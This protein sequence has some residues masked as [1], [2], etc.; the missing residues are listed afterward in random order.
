M[1]DVYSQ[2]ERGLA[3]AQ[4]AFAMFGMGAVMTLRDFSAVLL[5]PRALAVGLAVQLGA[6]PLLA[7]GLGRALPVPAGIAAGLVLV[8]A[9][10][11]GTLS[12]LATFLGR[13]NVAL[14]IALTAVTTVGALATTPAL[15]RLLLGA[16][17][18]ADFEMPVA[19]VARDIAATL[20][21]PLAAGMALGAALPAR[22]A[23]VS[24]WSIRA[25]L[26]M[27]LALAVGAAGSG[28]LD[29]RSYGTLALLAVPA[30][31]LCGQLAA[32]GAGRLAGL[33]P[34]DRL[35]LGIEATLRNTNLALLVKASLAPAGAGPDPLGDGMLFV[36][37][38]YGGF[39]LLASIPPI[40]LHRRSHARAMRQNASSPASAG[41]AARPAEP[42]EPLRR[43]WGQRHAACSSQ[44]S[45]AVGA[46]RQGPE[47]LPGPAPAR[48]LR[49][50]VPALLVGGGGARARRAARRARPEHR[51]RGGGPARCRAPRRPRRAAL[52]GQ[53]GRGP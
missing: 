43:R 1:P 46:D 52:A 31:A 17:L 47:A 19:Q 11:G 34:A 6:V 35:A 27:I 23:Q 4:L 9:V 3:A 21:G 12:N 5:A 20:L 41:D 25:S 32:V 18:P 33:T 29:P 51:A 39:A 13:G 38:L 44:R 30:L 7:L 22:R 36:A 28:R 24:R 2:L 53:G 42:P 16:Q 26:A 37:L 15:L 49:R 45:D 40:A 8:A 50:G 10:P 14:S 48:G